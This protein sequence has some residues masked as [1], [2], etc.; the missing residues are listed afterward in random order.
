MK[1]MGEREKEPL[2]RTFQQKV[3]EETGAHLGV[4]F[5]AAVADR[6]QIA[7]SGVLEAT[8]VVLLP[9]AL[10]TQGAIRLDVR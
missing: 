3:N 4:A 2:V 10:Q 9:F 8:I 6:Q 7:N 5:L 1:R